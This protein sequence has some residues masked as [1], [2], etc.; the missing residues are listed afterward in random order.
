MLNN[1]KQALEQPFDVNPLTHLW[2]SLDSTSVCI[3][4][5]Y[6][7]LAKMAVVHV[8]GS[9]QDERCFSSLSF[10]KNKLRNALDEHLE[11]VVGMYS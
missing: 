4:P 5:E 7:K 10:L 9:V 2:R 1:H 3:F 11:L 8:L 6:M